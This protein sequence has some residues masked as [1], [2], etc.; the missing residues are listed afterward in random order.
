[1]DFNVHFFNLPIINIYLSTCDIISIFIIIAA[2]GKSAQ[3]GLHAWLPD[4]M[5]GPTPVSALLH[6]ATMV[7]AGVFLLIRMASIL[8]RSYV[9]S[10]LLL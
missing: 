7:T 4:A 1:M 5:E 3:I 8:E 9:A 10:S 6:S 2:V